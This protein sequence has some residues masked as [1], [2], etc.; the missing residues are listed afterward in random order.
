MDLFTLDPCS[1]AVNMDLFT[2]DLGFCFDIGIFH[3][4]AHDANEIKPSISIA[5]KYQEFSNAFEKRN[6]DQLPEHRPYDYLE[7]LS[8]LWTD[9]RP[10]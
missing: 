4:K 9:L 7:C 8:S 6:L 3:A 10:F 5:S 2:I 1:K